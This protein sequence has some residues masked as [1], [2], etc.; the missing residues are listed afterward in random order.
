MKENRLK[1]AVHE[2]EVVSGLFLIIPSPELVEIM[3]KVGLDF[4]IIDLEHGSFGIDSAR[5][6]VL[7][8][9]A[10]SIVPL[11]RVAANEP[12]LIEQALNLG[13]QGVVVPHVNTAEEARRAVRAAK[14]PPAG[15]RGYCPFS[16]GG[17]Y[18]KYG[19]G[20]EYTERAN[21]ETMVVLLVEEPAGIEN[22]ESILSVEGVDVIFPGPGDLS[23]SLGLLGQLDHPT[24]QQKVEWVI[25]SARARGIAA[26]C[27]PTSYD[28]AKHWVSKG[29][30]VIV[31]LTD[32]NIFYSG[33][34][35][36]KQGLQQAIEEARSAA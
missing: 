28:G 36:V 8:A 22:L 23:A 11:I 19:G 3:G 29:A 17:H 21:A 6:C 27:L 34:Q 20:P 35:T 16:R 26:A 24:V 12:T 15:E 31:F 25:T 33:C 5:N 18:G 1:R 30:Q 32:V 9:D 13:A 7:A 14:Y 2:G 10:V 4:V